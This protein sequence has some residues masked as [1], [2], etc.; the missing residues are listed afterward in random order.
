MKLYYSPG[1][2]SLAD[3]IVLEW[4]G[5]PY[6]AVRVTREERKQP[7]FL[8]INPAGAVPVLEDG[9]WRLTQ[10]AAI[11]NFL[12]DSFPEAGLGGD[13]TPKSRAEANRWLAFVNSDMHPAFKPLFGSTAYLGDETAI[14][15]SK[16]D[17][18]K[19]LRGMFETADA[20]LAGKDWLIG[21]RSIA[22]PY[23]FVLTRWAKNNGIDLS[24]LSNLEHFFAN[25]LADAAVQ[26]AMQEEGLS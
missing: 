21:Q 18:K 4:I 26:K 3:H 9:G 12:A 17:A 2:C 22:D 5:K 16:A 6:E 14:E 15:K 10:N 11:L 13:G 19:K 20:Q 24:G 23:L 1:A 25:M 7:E 8:K